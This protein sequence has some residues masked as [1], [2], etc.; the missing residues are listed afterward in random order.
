MQ[1]EQLL[2]MTRKHRLCCIHF[3][4]SS[5]MQYFSTSS[6]VAFTMIEH[7]NLQRL[8]S[9]TLIYMYSQTMTFHMLSTEKLK[10]T[11]PSL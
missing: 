3:P 8:N 4:I 7:Y 1:Y 6:S 5:R 2:E 11:K 10:S 9:L